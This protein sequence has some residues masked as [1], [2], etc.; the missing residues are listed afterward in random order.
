[1][2]FVKNIRRRRKA[3]RSDAKSHYTITSRIK[4][5]NK[6]KPE[7]KSDKNDDVVDVEVTENVEE[8]TE[9]ENADDYVYGEVEVFDDDNKDN[10]NNN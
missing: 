4:T 5:Q 10:D 7:I 2:L 6:A 9:T 8:T 3:N 1:M